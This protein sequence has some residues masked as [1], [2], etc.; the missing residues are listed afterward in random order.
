VKIEL[1]MLQN[2]A[3]SCL[4]RDDSNAPKDCEFGGYRRARISSQ[5]LKRATRQHPL[6]AEIVGSA[7]GIRT[8]RLIS[9]VAQGLV[10]KGMDEQ[11]AEQAASAVVTLLVGKKSSDGRTAVAFYCSPLEIQRIIE[12]TYDARQE[13]SEGGDGAK[14]KKSREKA[15]KEL[16]KALTKEFRTIAAAADVALFGRMV[17]ERTDLNIDAACQVAHAISTNRAA[18]E[19]DFFTAVDDLQPEEEPGAG[20]MGTVEFNSSCFYR[21]A[22]V[23]LPQLKK[24]LADDAELA[25]RTVEAFL[26]ASVAA[27]P[28]GKQNS[29][30]AQNPPACVLAVVR[31]SGMP[32]S[33]A[34][35]FERP[36][37][38][39]QR[40]D[41]SL[42]SL[43]LKALDSYW[44]QLTQ[45]YGTEG[46]AAA[47]VCCLGEP[48]L[49]HL[50]CHAVADVEAV[51]RAV[52]EA[53]SADGGE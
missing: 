15:A 36:V 11:S 30:A 42:T 52:I 12:T 49:K 26:R 53:I 3:P 17:A 18:M 21:Y 39:P 9:E 25:T 1:H 16:A 27:I 29:M 43:S 5:C 4:N 14:A 8:R 47:A 20:M 50:T 7:P 33:L 23:D 10:D 46:I 28:T 34:N 45:M 2:F 44:G 40:A 35:A 22:M 41:Q 24:N 6:F 48:A 31:R 38:P 32:W 19:M 37:M 51:F 13:L